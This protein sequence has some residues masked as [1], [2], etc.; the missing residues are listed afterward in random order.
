MELRVGLSLIGRPAIPLC[1]L[2][3]VL[4]YAAAGDVHSSHI[5]LSAGVILVG[6]LAIPLCGLNV[7]P[8]HAL[9]SLE[10]SPKVKLSL[11][12]TL[13]GERAQEAQRGLVVLTRIRSRPLVECPAYS[14]QRHAG[15][16]ES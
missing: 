8:R 3:C 10:H 6:R 4:G 1:R 5:V 12:I 2:R 11:G 7:V 14:S 13:F 15:K 16:H 9:A